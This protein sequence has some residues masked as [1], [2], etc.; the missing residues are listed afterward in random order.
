[1]STESRLQIGRIAVVVLAL[2][3]TLLAME[4]DSKVL[5]VVSYAWA[6]LGASIGPAILVS[7]YWKK[8][9]SSGALAGIVVGGLTVIV[10]SQLEG[11][12]FNLYALVP[13]FIFSLVAIALVSLL[14]RKSE[15][16]V[17][18]SQFNL[19]EQ[20]VSAATIK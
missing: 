16:E 17:V 15:N 13:G 8:M 3:A 2:C 4:P 18:V 11:G 7:L 20:Q 6:G 9:T 19:M 10:W 5:D 14:D 1:L 12:I